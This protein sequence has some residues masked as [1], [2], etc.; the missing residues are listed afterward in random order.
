MKSLFIYLFELSFLGGWGY[1]LTM[2]VVRIT[3]IFAITTLSIISV[4]LQ[5][6]SIHF[7]NVRLKFS[8]KK[9]ECE[10]ISRNVLS[11]FCCTVS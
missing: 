2:Y 1:Q 9:A 10:K 3:I 8:H 7:T 4:S 5:D 6:I 11:R